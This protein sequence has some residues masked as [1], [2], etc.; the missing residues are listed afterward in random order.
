L[1][2]NPLKVQAPDRDDIILLLDEAAAQYPW[3]LLADP[4]GPERRPFAIEHGV[5]RQLET[6]EFTDTVRPVT[7]KAAL[8]IGDP[9]S[10]FVELKGAQVEAD[11]VARSL[12]DGSFRVELRKRATGEQVMQALYARPYQ[13][14][15][16]AGHGVYRYLPKRAG[17]CQECGR[18]LTD[19]QRMKQLR[20]L[21]PI[22][23]M[24][25]GDDAYLTP[26]EVKQLTRVP[27]LVFVNCCHLGRIEPS[28]NNKLNSRDDY[29][30]I[31]ANVATEFI[32]M[33][34][35]V[36]VAAGWAVD[37]AAALTFS[38][39]FY[40]RLLGGAVF[41]EAV[42]AARQATYEAYPQS[43]TW[44]AYQCYGDPAFRLTPN[45]GV[46]DGSDGKMRFASPIEAI[47]ELDNIA[48]R[49]WAK[50][51]DDQQKERTQ[52]A[53]AVKAIK[54]KGW[55]GNGR[56]C[57]PAARAYRDTGLFNHALWYY[58]RA[59]AVD[60]S[61][62]GFAD[63]EQ[64]ANLLS[65]RAVRRYEHPAAAAMIPPV[66]AKPL[67]D[68]DKAIELIQ[69]LI[70]APDWPR[71]RRAGR[72]VDEQSPDKPQHER[73]DVSGR[74]VER[75]C[76]LGSAYK[77]KAWVSPDPKAALEKMSEAYHDA[78]ALSESL[79][80]PDPYPLLNAAAAE[81]LVGWAAER[82]RP[83]ESRP[84]G[85]AVT[86]GLETAK[87]MLVRSRTDQNRYW[88]NIHDADV[89]LIEALSK[90]NL[91]KRVLSALADDY[92]EARKLGNRRTFSSVLD[93]LRFLRAMADKLGRE[94]AAQGLETLL[95]Q[96]RLKGPGRPTV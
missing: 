90:N 39:I 11:A 56:L 88:I 26:A 3:E 40:N 38:T 41:G 4:G 76:L 7:D 55:L 69:W 87:A 29:N 82:G 2:P 89:R 36:V 14:L 27:D 68:I 78:Y 30:K 17:E 96:L 32:R 62:V 51:G 72:K 85:K 22:T 44:G 80:K 49:L 74:T 79:K 94:Q 66:L 47:A 65:R 54:E 12:Q 33:G 64:I 42:K 84:T 92:A 9:I 86:V 31:A 10:S 73:R 63:I 24:I 21:E 61:A 53:A 28:G 93:Q 52:L 19:T 46:E 95:K 6:M 23:G 18:E 15:H 16:L 83:P 70:K 13:I 5:L 81:L 57:L 1:L 77:R 71:E 59:L 35:R 58:R 25:I 50:A 45:D 20:T 60:P 8:V 43:N 91:E 75:L 34:V 48:A 37:D 67:Q